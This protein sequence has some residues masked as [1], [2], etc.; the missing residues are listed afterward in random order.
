MPTEPASAA[1][2]EH[3]PD[4]PPR[5]LLIAG[6]VVALAALGGVLAIAATRHAPI[7]PVVIAAAPAPQAD[8][9]TCRALLD[10]LP[11]NLGEFHRVAAADPVPPGAAAWR[12]EAD[13]YP[14]VMRCGIDRPAEFVVGSPIQMVNAVQWF[15]LDD[16]DI[17]RSTWVTVDRPVYVALTLPTESGPTPIQAMSD[18]IARIIPAVPIDPNP[19]H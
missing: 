19:A 16:P 3:T 11:A 5:A 1:T 4:G 12:G 2:D 18:L 17:D 8:S 10:A 13:N 7:Q 6:I 9:P 14:V 15:R